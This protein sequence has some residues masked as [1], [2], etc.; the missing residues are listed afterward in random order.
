MNSMKVIAYILNTISSMYF[1]GGMLAQNEKAQLLLQGMENGFGNLINKLKNKEAIDGI[2]VLIRFFYLLTTGSFIALLLLGIFGIRSPK[3]AYIL[4]VLFLGAGIFSFS[5]IW[6]LKHNEMAKH[7]LRIVLFYISSIVF[8]FVMD[9]FG[10]TRFMHIVFLQEQPFLMHFLDLSSYNGLVSEGIVVLISLFA[11]FTF[12]YVSSWLL[13][14]FMS[15]IAW[16]M[17]LSP[18]YGAKYIDK[19]FP[20]QPIAIIFVVIWLITSIYLANF[21]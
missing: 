8:F 3:I 10:F 13:A 11:F 17:V 6:V 1:M 15:S 20:K 18:I 12:I 7:F 16:M 21:N 9:W 5:L 4:S 14:I 19:N 2:Y